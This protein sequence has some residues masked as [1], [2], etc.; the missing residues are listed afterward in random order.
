MPKTLI[1]LYILSLT[2]NGILY[3]QIYMDFR[4]KGYSLIRKIETITEPI[5][6]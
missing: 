5:P 3:A 4:Y 2:L 6:L 1:V